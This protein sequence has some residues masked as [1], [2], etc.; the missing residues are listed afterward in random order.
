MTYNVFGGMLNLTQPNPS[1][2]CLFSYTENAVG[3]IL[4]ILQVCNSMWCMYLSDVRGKKG[5]TSK[6]I[7]LFSNVCH[8]FGDDQLDDIIGSLIEAE[9]ELD[10][11]YDA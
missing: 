4:L 10:I 7:V 8:E 2:E 3:S 1:H 9:I 11:M 5:F 6:R